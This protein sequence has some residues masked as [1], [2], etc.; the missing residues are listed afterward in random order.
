MSRRARARLAAEWFERLDVRPNDPMLH[1]DRFSGGNQQK[2]VMAK[3][4]MAEDLR[5]LILDHPLRGL[6][7]GAA[8]TVNAQIRAAA[9]A[10]AAVVLIADTIEEALAM[11]DDILV[12][13][14]GEVTARYDLSVDSP[15]SLDLLG[16]MV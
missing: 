14:Y 5:V 3:W 15:T 2:V 8:E 4:L 7:P 9:Q 12:M 16:R 13:R 11:G 10:G 6:D 1:L